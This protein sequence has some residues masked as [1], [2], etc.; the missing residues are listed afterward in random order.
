MSS[1]SEF[2]KR[3]IGPSQEQQNQ[4]LEDLG[5]SCLDELVR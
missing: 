4:M 2:V 3:H 5:L 1:I